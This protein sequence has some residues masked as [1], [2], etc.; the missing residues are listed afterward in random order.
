MLCEPIRDYRSK[1]AI[2]LSICDPFYL[3]KDYKTQDT[4][5]QKRNAQSLK[6]RRGS[7][8]VRPANTSAR[9]AGS[10]SFSEARSGRSH[11]VL[12]RRIVCACVSV[13]LA[14][15]RAASSFLGRRDS[16][17]MESYDV[18]A[19]QPVV[20]DNVS[21]AFPISKGFY[22]LLPEGIAS[23][24]QPGPPA[25]CHWPGLSYRFSR[26]CL[27]APPTHSL[28]GRRPVSNNEIES[29]GMN[30]GKTYSPSR[31]LWPVA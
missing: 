13:A 1:C 28:Q 3:Y 29:F 14:A 24:L 19:N 7:E 22:A 21:C 17:A 5:R 27:C 8:A 20:I 9:P 26:R 2:Q 10:C 11:T 25:L 23:R 30:K 4:V 31:A 6:T 18:I 16:S 15:D 12:H